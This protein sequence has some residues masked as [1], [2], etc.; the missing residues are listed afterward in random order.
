MTSR[1]KKTRRKKII[2]C[3]VP[4]GYVSNVL[5][6]TNEEE[7]KVTSRMAKVSCTRAQSCVTPATSGSGD[8]GSKIGA[9]KRRRVDDK[10]EP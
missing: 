10:M 9:S 7:V 6:G 2:A 8:G 1:E 3:S 5:L 4:V